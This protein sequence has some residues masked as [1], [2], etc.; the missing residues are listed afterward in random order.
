MVVEDAQGDGAQ[1]LAAG[2]EHLLRT[3]MEIEAPQR[4]DVLGFV[5]ANLARL[6]PSFGA[7]F[8]RASVRHNH[9]LLQ[10]TVSLHVALDRGIRGEPPQ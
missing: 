6:V 4:P 1:P 9:G 7:G 5:A 8:A 3:V 2:S 10:Q